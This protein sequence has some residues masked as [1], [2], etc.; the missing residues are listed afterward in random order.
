MK[1]TINKMNKVLLD[2]IMSKPFER[3]NEID[4]NTELFNLPIVEGFNEWMKST[5]KSLHY[6]N[7]IDMTKAFCKVV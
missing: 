3:L 4:V 5:V 1:A 7:D 2:N 6:H